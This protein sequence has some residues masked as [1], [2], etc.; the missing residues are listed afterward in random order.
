MATMW[1]HMLETGLARRGKL[2]IVFGEDNL[3]RG[4]SLTLVEPSSGREVAVIPVTVPGVKLETGLPGEAVELNVGMGSD[5]MLG[6][7]DRMVELE[8]ARE[9]ARAG[10]QEAAVKAEQEAAAQVAKDQQAA[11]EASYEPLAQ[12]PVGARTRTVVT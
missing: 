1:K 5:C 2:E 7:W 11:V 3:P 4:A 12:P 10:A 9:Q 6:I 8:E